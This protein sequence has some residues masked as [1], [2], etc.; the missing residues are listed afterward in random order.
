MKVLA[1]GLLLVAV[2]AAQVPYERIVAAEKEPGNWLTYSGNYQGHRYSPLSQLTPANVG[3]LK[4]RWAKQFTMGRTQV[5]PIVVDGIMYITAPNRAEALDLRSGNTLWKWERPIPRDYQSIGFGQV[6]RGP[7]ILDDKLYVAT[8]DCYLVA[9]DAKTGQQRWAVKVEDYKPGYS[10]TLAPLAIKGKVIVGVSGGEAGIRGFV[11]AY[12]AATGKLA[13]RFYTIPG[14]GEPGHE[15]WAG[16]SWKTGAGSSWVTGSYDAE[17]NL[18]Y[19]GIGNP[20]PD[21]NGD[22]RK[23]DNLYS[24]SFVA[25]DGDTGK[26]KWHFQFTPH[27]THDWDSTHV[28][29]L[30]DAEVRGKKRKLVVN[31][32]RNAFYYALDRVTGEFVA[33]RE[34][35][36]QTWAKGLDDKGRPVPVPG[37]EPNA[38]GVLVWPALN[39]ATV[40]F[41]PS[42][43]PRTGLLYV[44]TRESGAT[45]YKREAEYKPG[46]FFAGGGETRIPEREQWGA[47]RALEATSGKKVWEFRLQSPPWAG[48]LSTAGGLVFSGTNEGN[49]FAVDAKTGQPL[50]DFQAGGMVA[51]NPISF[52][53][54]GKQHVALAAERVLY[55]F[56]LP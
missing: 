45:Y 54:D 21:W 5:S 10:M 19:W 47:L 1:I 11:D 35:A 39:G 32:N 2:L 44:M 7:A 42:Y 17:L 27:D 4:V 31:P 12:D 18:V 56:G 53:V 24:C 23:G 52:L 13:W 22:S 36:K 49:I 34:Y 8:L 25:L 38:E 30:L 28:P 33:G 16:D 46:T 37:M 15:T 29:V 43:S 26:L 41:S 48:V 20:G 55:V 9:L 40:W 6:N 51:A 3:G 14:P 50:W